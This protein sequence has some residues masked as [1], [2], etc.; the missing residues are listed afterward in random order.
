[1]TKPWSLGLPSGYLLPKTLT[2]LSIL[3]SSCLPKEE[4]KLILRPQWPSPSKMKPCWVE[5][6]AVDLQA[7]VIT[8]LKIFKKQLITSPTRKR[9][10]RK[11]LS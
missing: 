9:I 11:M 1:L 7:K 6:W 5:P 2:E 10:D 8:C 3:P 4:S